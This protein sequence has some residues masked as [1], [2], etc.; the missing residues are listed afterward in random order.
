VGLLARQ[1]RGSFGRY[2]IPAGTGRRGHRGD[3]QPFDHRSRA[4]YDPVADAVLQEVERELGGEYGAAQVHQDHDA[5]A[6][7]GGRDGVHDRD[8]VGAERRLVQ[9]GGD[10]D[11]DRARVHHLRREPDRRA[12]QG[13]AVG[14]HHDADHRSQLPVPSVV[15]AA[16]SSSVTEVA[17]GSWWPTLRSPR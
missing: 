16:V 2:F 9:P 17:P 13:A 10:L 14:D 5:V 12:R 11:P 8:R 3:N 1:R 6:A 15:P 7:V 4:E